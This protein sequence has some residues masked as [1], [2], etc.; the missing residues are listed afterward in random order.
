MWIFLDINY[1]FYLNKRKFD[2]K[3]KIEIFFKKNKFNFL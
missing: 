2:I 1:L 3:K